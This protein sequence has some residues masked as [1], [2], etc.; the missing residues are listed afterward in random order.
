[1]SLLA[2]SAS[3]ADM[4]REMMMDYALVRANTLKLNPLQTVQFR[5]DAVR[6]YF[7]S[8]MSCEAALRAAQQEITP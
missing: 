7:G 2:D 6:I 1:M 5:K 3:L 8:A 4:G